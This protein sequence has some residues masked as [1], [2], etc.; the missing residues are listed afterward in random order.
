MFGKMLLE[1]KYSVGEKIEDFLRMC[2]P[3]TVER[4]D[5][6]WLEQMKE[7]VS[8]DMLRGFNCSRVQLDGILPYC[9]HVVEE[10]LYSRVYAGLYQHSLQAVPL[11]K[12]YEDFERTVSQIVRFARCP[13]PGLQNI[14]IGR[15]L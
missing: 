9:R 10:F 5:I 6:Q 12:E 3:D 7:E 1:T 4:K 2:Q 11:H 14:L 13:I 15:I 8:A